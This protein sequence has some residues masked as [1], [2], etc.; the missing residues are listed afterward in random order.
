MSF[1]NVFDFSEMQKKIF[2]KMFMLLFSIQWKWQQASAFAFQGKKIKS[3]RLRMT[4]GWANEDWI[5]TLHVNYPFN[6]IDEKE[7]LIYIQNDHISAYYATI[8]G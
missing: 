8:S 1:K 4:W 3:N 2:C 6:L 5:F 7:S